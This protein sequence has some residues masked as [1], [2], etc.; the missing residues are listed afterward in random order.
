MRP[1]LCLF[2]LLTAILPGCASPKGPP[3]LTLTTAQYPAAFEAAK[4]TLTS[5]RFE[6]DRVDAAAGI[7]TTKPKPS[8]GFATPWDE[9]QSGL[10][11]ELED[12]LNDQLRR[13]RITFE[14]AVA[15]GAGDPAPDLR[16]DPGPI[17]G[18]IEVIVD[19]V[20]RAGWRLETTSMR[21]SS[22][23][24]DPAL[25]ERG[26]WPTYTVPLSQDPE[27]AA[28][29]ADGIRRRLEK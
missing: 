25:V 6:L 20:R 18:R 10:N 29:L 26:M 13:V 9:E 19:R 14:T 22:F 4:D 15:A 21:Y 7:I 11:Q 12:F 8:A 23:T 2:V 28:R 17:T 3:E 1:L 16:T 5:Y 27:L 24:R